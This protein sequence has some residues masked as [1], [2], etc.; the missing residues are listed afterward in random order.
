MR[1]ASLSVSMGAHT[2]ISQYPHPLRRLL[3]LISSFTSATAFLRVVYIPGRKCLDQRHTRTLAT[4]L[5]TCISTRWLSAQL[6]LLA[7]F[8]A[9]APRHTGFSLFFRLRRRLSSAFHT[10]SM[11]GSGLCFDAAHTPLRPLHTG[12]R[13][14]V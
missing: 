6:W 13:D 1:L 11:L 4:L 12:H 9:R 8:L 10:L 3:T 5:R 14:S 2:I 7:G